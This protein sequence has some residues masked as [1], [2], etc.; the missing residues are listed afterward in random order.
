MLL[1]DVSKSSIT[2]EPVVVIP[3]I[4]SKKDSLKERFKLESMKGILPKRAILIHASDENRNACLR[5][6][7]FSF[8]KLVSTVKIPIMIV[9]I[10]DEKKLLLFSLYIS[11]I[12]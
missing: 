10:A 11:C 9:I 4:L 6:S 5:F 8:V 1:G 3:D 7:C 12:A 2:V